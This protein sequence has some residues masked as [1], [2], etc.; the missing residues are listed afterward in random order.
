MQSTNVNTV[1]YTTDLTQPIVD[2]SVDSNGDFSQTKK[3]MKKLKK[4]QYLKQKKDK[5]MIRNQNFKKKF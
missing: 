2:I 3:N 4:L 1:R 5:K